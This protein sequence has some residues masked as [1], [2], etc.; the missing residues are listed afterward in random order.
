MNLQN[1]RENYPQ[2]ISYMETNDYS[3]TSVDRF[4]RE[5]I[6]IIAAVDSKEWLCYTVVYLE[7]TKTSHLPDFLRNKRTIIGAIEQFYV[8]GR[9]PDGRRRH[10][11]G[12]TSPC[13][14]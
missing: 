13:N 14:T 3:K 7:Y 8:H 10:R 12:I 2:L 9:Y 4:K 11:T 5:I 6:K 1:L